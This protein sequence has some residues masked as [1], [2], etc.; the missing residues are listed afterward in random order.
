MMP[1]ISELKGLLDLAIAPYDK[2]K[3]L[4][5]SKKYGFTDASGNA[6]KLYEISDTALFQSF[7]K[8]IVNPL[9]I[10]LV[11]EGLRISYLN[12]EGRKIEI[13]KIKHEVNKR[14]GRFGIRIMQIASTGEL[15]NIA[16]YLIDLNLRKNYNILD[17]TKEF[18]KIV[19]NWLKITSFIKKDYPKEDIQKEIISH[20][21]REEEIFF[22]F[23]YGSAVQP[24][25]E[26]IAVLNIE[27]K[28]SEKYIFEGKMSQDKSGVEHYTCFFESVTL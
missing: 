15:E 3:K 11:R 10:S 19:E 13:D 9:Y 27:H 5:L 8:C 2:I 1:N 4:F 7:K 24:T 18:E 12:D 21:E 20:I 16:K 25:I 6:K 28:F 26:V 23:A 17:M 22:V 14:Y